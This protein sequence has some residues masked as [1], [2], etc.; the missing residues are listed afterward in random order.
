[1]PGFPRSHTTTQSL[2]CSEAGCQEK[3][4]DVCVDHMSAFCARHFSAH[5]EQQHGGVVPAG[6]VK[7]K[8]KPGP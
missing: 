7:P 3:A 8:P 6:R 4:K 5:V 1:M 2:L